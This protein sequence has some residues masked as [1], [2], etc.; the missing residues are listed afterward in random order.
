MTSK[1]A[2]AIH[3]HMPESHPTRDT[4]DD[5]NPDALFIG[6][7]GDY[8]YDAAILGLGGQYGSPSLVVYS[9]EKLL[10][11]CKRLFDETEGVAEDAWGSACGWVDYSIASVSMSPGTPIIVREVVG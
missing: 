8:T 2:L 1:A 6:E 4:I 9:Y 5:E 7:P 11:C 3:K 10:D